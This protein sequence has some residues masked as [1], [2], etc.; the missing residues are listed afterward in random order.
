MKDH[1]NFYENL[2]EAQMRLRGTVVL[3]DGE[4]YYVMC[5][6]NH[7]PDGIFRIYLE[8]IG[9]DPNKLIKKPD[10]YNYS[11]DDP[12]CGV[13]MDAWLDANTSSPIIRKMMNS[14]LFNNYRPFPLGMCNYGKSTYYIERQPQ[15]KT[16]QGLIASMLQETCITAGKTEVSPMKKAYQNVTI[17]SAEFRSCILAIHPTAQATLTALRD[18]TVDN[19]SVAFHREFALVRGPIDMLFLAY[20]SDVIGVMPTGDFTQ[21]RLGAGFQH[22]REVVQNLKL[23]TQII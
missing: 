23:F 10:P 21:L 1:V 15:R 13:M 11:L 22:T 20:K 12:G 6:T 2:K 18:P 9:Q 16:E 8:P 3:Y 7:K 4:P 5:I 19:E 14:K 17:T